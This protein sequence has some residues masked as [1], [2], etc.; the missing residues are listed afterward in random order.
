M[1][2][3]APV[4]PTHIAREM[5]GSSKDEDFLGE[6]HLLLAHDV[7]EHPDAY[8][9]VYGE[10]RKRYGQESFIILDNSIVELGES[11]SAETLYEA[12]RIIK[13]DCVV[14]P[15]VMGDGV[16]TRKLSTKFHREWRLLQNKTEEKLPPL[17][18]VAQGQSLHDCLESCELFYILDDVMYLS[19]PRII[20]QTQGSRMPI[21]ERLCWRDYFERVHL[22]GFSD[23]LLD[24][25]TCARMSIVEGIDSAVPIR[26][27][28]E[29]HLIDLADP[30]KDFGP[31]GDFWTRQLDEEWYENWDCIQTNLAVVRNSI[32]VH[33]YT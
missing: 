28:A 7:L 12:A 32:C 2:R 26:A 5:Q 11:V 9:E 25:I 8:R 10:V 13:P 21:I 14:A 33:D 18:G 29:G 27:G 3:F 20:Q 31:R 4:V 15:D 17:M 30:E 22:L 1:A 16:G 19:V 24:D 23:D 6:Y